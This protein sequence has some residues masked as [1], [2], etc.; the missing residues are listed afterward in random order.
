MAKRKA[1]KTAA[2]AET[3]Q[4]AEATVSLRPE[5]GTQAQFKKQKPPATYRYDSSLSPDLDWDAQNA[6]REVGESQL[7][8]VGSQLQELRKLLATDHGQLTNDQRRQIEQGI[9]KAE[10]AVRKLVAMS[11]PF[12][13]WAGKAERLSF[14]VPTLPLFVHERLSTQAILRTLKGHKRD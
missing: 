3:Y 13:N 14:D 2:Q 6:T 7:S 11:R 10:D 5:V 1:A 9:A 12:L 4:H 8:V